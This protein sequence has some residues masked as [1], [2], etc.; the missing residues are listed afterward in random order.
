MN[1]HLYKSPQIKTTDS[2]PFRVIY[3]EN[4]G[5][6][7]VEIEGL[8]T[9]RENL[10]LLHK[11]SEQVS[12]TAANRLLINAARSRAIPSEAIKWKSEHYLNV[13]AQALPV[14]KK[15]KIARIEPAYI[16][17]RLQELV[18]EKMSQAI[19]STCEFGL[20]KDPLAAREWLYR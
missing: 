4:L 9:E 13:L 1:A 17:N 3:D 16:F 11:I 14:E 20:F 6:I 15:I 8:V 18:V 7:T 2:P 10:D 5:L 12:L 19:A